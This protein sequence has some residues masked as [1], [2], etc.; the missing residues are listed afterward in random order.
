MMNAYEMVTNRIIEMLESGIIPWHKP[1]TGVNTGAHNRISN[2]PYS[3]LNQMLLKHDGEYATYKQWHDIGGQ[4]R[5]GEKAETVVFWKIQEYMEKDADGEEK[6][7][8][9]PILKYYS[10]FHI[11]QVDG[12]EPKAEPLKEVEP[13]A[14]AEKVKEDYKH[15]ERLTITE[16]VTN[17][18]YYSPGAD[19]INVPG[20]NQYTNINEFYSTLFHEMVHSTGHKS[21]LD[22]LSSGTD[23]YFGSETY[24]KEELVAELGSAMLLNQVG[25]ETT[26]TLTN[27]AAYIQGWIKVLKNDT[28]FIVSASSKAEKAVGY[29]LTGTK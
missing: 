18:A 27:S 4:V 9:L 24:S 16:K 12:V 20:R 5:R 14:E 2:K 22:R 3:L 13:I 10:V 17:E 25:I 21:R 23:S 11:S 28:H 29:I 6:K 15:R 1:W 26:K 7:K 19:C 8:I